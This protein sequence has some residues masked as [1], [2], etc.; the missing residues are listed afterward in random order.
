MA[1]VGF[2]A[3][4]EQIPPEQLLRDV[5]HAEQAGF[6]AAMCSDHLE[7]WS[8]R[9]GHAGFALS[10]LG[11]A[12]ASTA[13]PFG[14][15]HAPGRRYHPVVTA[16]A[17]ATLARMFP[18]RVW[19]A[20]GT[21]QRLNERPVSPRWP[22][23]EE[24]QRFLEASFDVVR[25]LHA[26]EEVTREKPFRADRARVW[27]A[28]E[29]L[30]P[31]LVPALTPGTAR[32]FAPVA[33][34][35]ITVNQPLEDLRRMLDAYREGGGTGRTVLQVHLSWAP[36]PEQARA[37][38][39]DQWR[40]NVFDPVT[41][42][43]LASPQ[44]YERKALQQDVGDE[45]VAGAV[46]VSADLGRHAQWLHEYAELGF[47]ELQLHHVGREQAPFLDAFGQEVLP[48]LAG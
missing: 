19:V 42:A 37:I 47:D 23:K 11:A 30:P 15:V 27:S 6:A 33:D 4:H 2:H 44:D 17:T 29:V 7:P 10:W 26:G 16:Q 3:S 48:Q 34:G 41:M 21:G 24:R 31:L 43:E 40:T 39:R 25:R 28:P 8:P 45:Q 22:A 46:N 18:G 20:L 9:Q 35:L 12:L 36:E 13:L 38:A 1:T 14:F 5:R 32:R